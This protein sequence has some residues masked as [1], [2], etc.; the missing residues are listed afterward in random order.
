MVLTSLAVPHVEPILLSCCV[1]GAGEAV[2][3]LQ[4]E[5]VDPSMV[6]Y[7][8]M[9]KELGVNT[10]IERTHEEV[11]RDC[12]ECATLVSGKD[13]ASVKHA[14]ARF[15]KACVDINPHTYEHAQAGC[16]KAAQQWKEHEGRCI[17]L[18]A[19]LNAAY[20]KPIRLC[21][22]PRHEHGSHDGHVAA[23][24]QLCL[25]QYGSKSA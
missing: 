4:F 16:S 20:K 18:V 5:D 3:H 23:L 2:V 10:V 24:R 17:Y 19:L 22:G 8:D 12:Q 1:S 15:H 7:L 11:V 25:K 14:A 9:S 6:L 21:Y 13:A